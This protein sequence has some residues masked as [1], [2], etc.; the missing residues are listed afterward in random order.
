MV[1]EIAAIVVA[2][3]LLMV[4]AFRGLPVIVFAPV[5]A[6]LAVGLSGRAMLPSYNELFMASAAGYVRSFFPLFLLGAIFG[7]LMETSG[8]AGSIAAVIV[9]VLGP[10][11]SILAVVAACVVLTYGGVSLFVVAFA[12]Y[13]FSAALFREADIPKRLI[14]GTIALGAFTLTMDALPGSPQIQNLIPTRY[15]GTDAYAAPL[16]GTLGGVIVLLGGL[17]WL[18]HRRRRAVAAGEGYGTGHIHE[19]DTEKHAARPAVRGGPV[20]PWPRA[21]R[22]L[23]PEP[24]I[25]VD[26]HVVPA[27]SN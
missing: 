19:P 23:R 6:M 2:L 18:E 13:P 21:G 17:F 8:A 11:R 15:Y 26:R 7:K 9:R 10:R 16:A 12:V 3:V 22:E 5:C 25:V 1:L 24:N 14:P 27:P 4:I 20:A